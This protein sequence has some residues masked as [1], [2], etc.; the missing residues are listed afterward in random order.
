MSA[1]GGISTVSFR[2]RS[3]K[4]IDDHVSVGIY[5]P[6]DPYYPLSVV[7]LPMT[8]EWKDYKVALAQGTDLCYV[9]FYA[10]E[11]GLYLH[12][13]YC[14]LSRRSATAYGIEDIAL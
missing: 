2:A 5:D 13:Q 8:G 11:A 9:Q 10:F 7:D 3:D 4:S 1:N 12:R 14:H 6:D